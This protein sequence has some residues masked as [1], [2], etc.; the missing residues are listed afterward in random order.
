MQAIF[1]ALLLCVSAVHA[2]DHQANLI[3]VADYLELEQVND[4][5]ISPDGRQVIYTR[6]YID[7]MKDEW[8]S[9]LW[10]MGAD[11]SRQRFLIDGSNA[12]WSPDG[13]RILFLAAD[14]NGK[15]QVFIRWMDADG[16]VSQVTRVSVTPSTPTWSPDGKS[17]AFVAIVPAKA[18]WK[19]DMPSPPEGAEWTKPP[20]ILD[21]L[22]YR[23]DRVGFRDPGY[24]H[25]FVVPAESGSARQLTDG[26]WHVGAQFDG[27]FFGAGLS[28]TPDSKRIIFDGYDSP[29][30]DLEY[31]RS[32]LYSIDAASGEKI[33]LTGEEGYWVGPAV[34]PNGNNIA[35]LGYPATENTYAMPRIYVMDADGADTRL[36]T[37]AF[38]RP[39]NNLFWD[40]NNR[41]I[42]FTAQD[43]GYVNVFRS[44]LN[45]RVTPVTSGKHSVGLQSVN[46]AR[47]VGAGVLSSFY[48][49]GDVYTFSLSGQRE[50]T[51]LTAVNADMLEGKTLGEHTEIWFE[52]EDGNR[53][54]GWIVKPPNF[55]PNQKY[56]MV[57]EIHGGPFAMYQGRFDFRYQ[58]FA[59]QGF[60]V[61]YT[62]PRGS[63]G[64]GEEFSLGINKAYPSVDYLDLMGGVDA[65]IAQGYIDEKRMYVGGCSGG[66][67]L[68]SWVIGHTDRFAAAAVRCPVVNWISMAG[69]TDVPNFT[70]SFFDK[71]FWDDPDA[72]LKTSSLMYVENVTTPTLVMTGEEDLRTPMAQSEEYYAALK[73]RGVP[74]KLMRF[75]N[76]YHG[77]GSKP[78]N[79][80][81]TLLYMMSW[82]KQWTEDG[83]VTEEDENK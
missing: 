51:R 60:V 81:R 57:F 70:L 53:A 82:Y 67:V 83:E 44:D 33:Q 6:R 63:T 32:H 18:E 9:S 55:D 62:N 20:R 17:I 66:G 38:D 43:E 15:P 27:L 52:A 48:E 78:S 80:M 26:E 74:A 8:K 19:I 21:R 47:R 25:L 41:G 65:A 5:Q 68:S 2:D 75:D 3:E 42:L 16:A 50:P 39:P 54:H 22:H 64:Y 24:S 12:R 30:H 73:V 7:Q 11:G 79:A 45:G 40:A 56:P 34:S 71:P 35:F 14:A 31:R 13:T 28:W 69:T 37:D 76:E 49:P 72:W 58:A 77:T 10:I 46:G 1:V 61:L 23:Q 59:A 29:D 36:L 4:A